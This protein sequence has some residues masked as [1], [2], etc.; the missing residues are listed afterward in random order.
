MALEPI[1]SIM[2][3]QA[4]TIQPKPTSTKPSVEYTDVSLAADTPKVD[5][6]TRVVENTSEKSDSNNKK[7]KEPSN[8]T[9]HKAIEKINK[10]MTNS[11]AIYGFHDKTN[12]VTIKIID[13]ETKEVIKELPP[14]K[15]LDLIAKAW[16]LAGILVDEKR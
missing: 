1:N 14:E 16:E 6:T 5:N 8:E 7:E 13:K 10:Q 15:T 4:Q 3:V 9:L 11:E 2:T 12:R